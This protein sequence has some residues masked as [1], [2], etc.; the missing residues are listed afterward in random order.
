MN[1]RNDAGLVGKSVVVT[2]AAGGI[3]SAVARGFAEAGSKVLLVD[4]PSSPLQETLTTLTGSGHKIYACDLSDLTGHAKIFEKA[5]EVAEV[6]ALAHCAA[7]LR[8]RATVDDVTEEDW[9]FQI[10]INMKAMFFLNRSARDHFKKHSTKGSIVNFSS[11]GWWTGGF[12]GSVVYAGSKGGVVSMTKGLARSF[13]ADGIRVNAVS[14]GGVDTLMMTGTQTPEQLASFV[15]MIPMG[16]LA[17]P[18]EMVGPVIF[19]ASQASSFVTGTVANVSGG[20]LM[21]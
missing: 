17:S 4:I 6:V 11:Q 2:G 14:P 12:G 19:L 20:Q 13:A 5:A 21:Y 9:D 1:W 8:R 7:V 16:R 15:S 18:E 10:D 3:G